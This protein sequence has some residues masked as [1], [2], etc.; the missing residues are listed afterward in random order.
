MGFGAVGW[1]GPTRRLGFFMLQALGFPWLAPSGNG[2][3]SSDDLQKAQS[4]PGLG[5]SPTSRTCS[6]LGSRRGLETLSVFSWIWAEHGVHGGASK[7]LV[8]PLNHLADILRG[9][10]M[11]LAGWHRI[12]AE[13]F[14]WG[15]AGCLLQPI[16]AIWDGVVSSQP[17][18]SFTEAAALALPRDGVI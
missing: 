11:D 15:A 8:P 13:G 2:A 10:A 6:G 3:T 16:P 4:L 18:S 9:P 12:S 1:L 7:H 14:V 17:S 5:R